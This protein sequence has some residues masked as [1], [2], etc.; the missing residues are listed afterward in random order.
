ML[1]KH[2][3]FNPQT[4]APIFKL[5]SEHWWF[6]SRVRIILWVL[7]TK[8]EVFCNFLE[9]GCGTGYV[10]EAVRRKYKNVELTGIEF[11]EEGLEL[12]RKRLPSASFFQRDVLTMDEK[13]CYDIIGAFDVLEHIEEDAKVLIN[14]FQALKDTGYVIITVPQHK[15]LWSEIDR[16]ACHIRRYSR[17]ELMEKV[18]CAGFQIEYTS[19]FVSLL[20]PLMW[21]SRSQRRNADFDPM[22]EFN[23]SSWINKIL[24]IVMDVEYFLLKLGVSFPFGGSLLLVARKP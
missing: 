13:K 10:L 23:V 20:M 16:H 8:V 1:K 18:K 6:C 17:S 11:F 14:I 22:R 2:L 12:A 4:F 5:E 15:W 3:P 9:I 7:A 24:K 21:L 19:S